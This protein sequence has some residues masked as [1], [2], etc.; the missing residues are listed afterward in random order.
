MNILTIF[1]DMMRPS[2]LHLFDATQPKRKMDQL[3]EKLGGTLYTNMWTSGPD[4]ARSLSQFWSGIPSYKNGCN[5][6]A[7]YPKFFLKDKDFL[8]ILHENG[9]SINLFSN[10]EHKNIGCFPPYAIE[11]YYSNTTYDIKTFF[12]NIDRKERNAFT[13]VIDEDFHWVLDDLGAGKRAVEVAFKQVADS[14]E[15]IL[16]YADADNYDM[17]IIFSDHGC[18]LYG[19]TDDLYKNLLSE[20]RSQVLSFV[21]TKESKGI[22]Y[23]HKFS[24]IGDYYAFILDFCNIVYPSN[25]YSINMSSNKEHEYICAE[26]FFLLRSALHM[27]VD[28]WSVR[29]KD[30]YYFAQFGK[31]TV[32]SGK[33]KLDFEKILIQECP[34]YASTKKVFDVMNYYAE[35]KKVGKEK[36]YLNGQQRYWANNKAYIKKIKK[37]VY[38]RYFRK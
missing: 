29:T 27:H 1:V 12:E 10:E 15:K 33:T 35:L 38:N 13:F 30:S 4:T 25:E 5:R 6:R 11:R 24:S 7:R 31:D 22:C 23:N 36:T 8:E 34:E 3:F 37:R 18:L 2:F 16:E 9:Y 28:M 26:D 14:I 21:H 17:I 32:F 20:K 19:E